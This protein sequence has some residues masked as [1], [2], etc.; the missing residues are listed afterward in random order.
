MLDGRFKQTKNRS[1]AFAVPMLGFQALAVAVATFGA[2]IVRAFH[3]VNMQLWFCYVDSFCGCVKKC[4]LH[5]GSGGDM[6]ATA[7]SDRKQKCFCFGMCCGF[8]RKLW[9]FVFADE[10]LHVASSFCSERFCPWMPFLLSGR[11][12]LDSFVHQ[13]EMIYAT[14]LN[15]VKKVGA[16]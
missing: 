1:V 16:P 11:Y 14:A 6:N 5:A 13:Q 9:H 10:K 7:T 15:C 8:R 4:L 12:C 2:G 3:S